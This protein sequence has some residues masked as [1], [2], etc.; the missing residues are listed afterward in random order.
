MGLAHKRAPYQWK[1]RTALQEKRI[2]FLVFG[3]VLGGALAFTNPHQ[4]DHSWIYMLLFGTTLAFFLLILL[5]S[6]LQH[7]LFRNVGTVALGPRV[8]TLSSEGIQE[9]TPHTTFFAQWP[10][11]VH[12]EETAT[13]VYVFL[14]NLS[15][16]IIPKR[17]LSADAQLGDL[18]TLLQTHTPSFVSSQP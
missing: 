12:S 8:L 15:G 18:R 16:F 4:N 10:A 14:N 13:H 6:Y 2:F 3:F 17:D 7:R 5:S 11:T 9:E 1:S